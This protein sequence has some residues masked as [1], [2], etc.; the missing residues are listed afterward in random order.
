MGDQTNEAF[1]PSGNRTHISSCQASMRAWIII[2]LIYNRQG[3]AL[4]STTLERLSKFLIFW[5]DNCPPGE[6][7]HELFV[8]FYF[9]P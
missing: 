3:V 5:L 1:Y 8:A 6:K 4:G 7:S 9:I 2:I